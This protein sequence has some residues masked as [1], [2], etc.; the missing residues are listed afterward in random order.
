MDTHSLP[1]RLHP[2]QVM[3]EVDIRV[4]AGEKS[5]YSFKI[6]VIG[7]AAVG[8]S[9]LL[10]RFTDDAYRSDYTSTIGIDFSTRL[11][12]VG[13]KVIKLEIWDT[14]GQE[15]FSTITANY[16]RGAQG[17][18]LVYDLTSFE[19]FASARKWADKVRG[20]SD[21]TVILR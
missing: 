10:L 15:R 16:Y 5:D 2:P 17:V 9:A 20:A 7:D 4:A 6:L 18:L 13:G 11:V 14:A 1:S 3:G 21:C 8:K 19:S 12:R